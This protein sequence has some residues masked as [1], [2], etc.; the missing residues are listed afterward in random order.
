MEFFLPN[1][2]G[3]DVKKLKEDTDSINVDQLLTLDREDATTLG[4]RGTPTFFL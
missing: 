2:E 1:I 3:L 4:V